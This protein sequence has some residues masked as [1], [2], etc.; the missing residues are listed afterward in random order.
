M[1]EYLHEIATS[2]NNQSY[3]NDISFST[4]LD[5]SSL[6]INEIENQ[7]V[8]GSTLPTILDCKAKDEARLD[9]LR[10]VCLA[11]L[12]DPEHEVLR[13]QVIKLVE[14]DLTAANIT[15]RPEENLYLKVGLYLVTS[16]LP[17][18]FIEAQG[19]LLIIEGLV[20]TI[21]NLVTRHGQTRGK[22]WH[23]QRSSKRGRGILY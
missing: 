15:W 14:G 12:R 5:M 7:S 23:H 8:F 11:V 17:F 9:M 6:N 13:H 20:L 21:L 10:T 4:V 1:K 3:L 2:V 22:T 19:S 16:L 18:R